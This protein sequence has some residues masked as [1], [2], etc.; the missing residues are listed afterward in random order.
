MLRCGMTAR[1]RAVKPES[2]VFPVG[3]QVH[4]QRLKPVP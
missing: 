1:A 4:L 2:G 3:A